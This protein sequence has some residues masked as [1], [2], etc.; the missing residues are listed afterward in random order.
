MNVV[1]SEGAIG[2]SLGTAD[3]LGLALARSDSPA[4]T[5]Y[6]LLGGRC[7]C[8]CAFCAQARGCR[9]RDDRLSRVTWPR[10]DQNATLHALHVAHAE[11]R[12]ARACLQVTSGPGA[13]AETERLLASIRRHGSVPVCA[14]V[15]PGSLRGVERLLVAG[16][17]VVG[18][19]LDAAT[20]MVYERIKTPGSPN[21]HG[22]RA[23]RRQMALIEAASRRFPKRIGVHLIVGLGETERELVQLTQRLVDAGVLVALFAFTPVRGTPMEDVLPPALDAYRRCQA[24]RHLVTARATRV[25]RFM[26]DQNGRISGFGMPALDLRVALSDG[27]AFRT[28]GCPGC[29]RPYYNERPR[30]VMYNYPR[31]LDAA[32]T[33]AALTLLGLSSETLPETDPS[34]SRS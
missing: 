31:A 15:L 19:G 12:I 27:Q 10:H 1:S 8:D 14:A 26:F 16:A 28:S 2:V 6:F 13:L 29:N 17:D 32:E 33:E 18:F 23:W 9:S 4:T 20:P 24:A 30:G 7:A 11:G 22:Q 34:A 5:A 25:E 21:G 3:A